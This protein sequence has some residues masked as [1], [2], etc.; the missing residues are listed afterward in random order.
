[1]ARGLLLSLVARE[2]ATALGRLTIS[3][4]YPVY[5]LAVGAGVS[6]IGRIPVAG[7]VLLA[8]IAGNQDQ[9]TSTKTL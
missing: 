2:L 6:F 4:S 3:Y 5:S 7:E 1:M 8:G 9:S